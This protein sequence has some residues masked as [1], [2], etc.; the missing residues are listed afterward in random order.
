M[1]PG[2]KKQRLG[3]WDACPD[4]S[5]AAFELRAATTT[6]KLE[7]CVGE[8]GW[9]EV[10][11]FYTRLNRLQKTF[12]ASSPWYKPIIVT[13]EGANEGGRSFVEGLVDMYPQ[14]SVRMACTPPASLSAVQ[15]MFNQLGG[16][17]ARAFNVVSNY[18]VVQECKDAC[19]AEHQPLVFIIANFLS[20]AISCSQEEVSRDELWVWPPGLLKPRLQLILVQDAASSG[21]LAEVSAASKLEVEQ[22]ILRVSGLSKEEMLDMAKGGIDKAFFPSTE[23]LQSVLGAD[24]LRCLVNVARKEGLLGDSAGDKKWQLGRRGKHVSW[25]FQLATLNRSSGAPPSLRNLGIHS[26]TETGFIFFGLGSAG[27]ATGEAGEEVVASMVLLLGSYPFQQQWRGEG[28]VRQMRWGS[29]PPPV[30]LACAMQRCQELAQHAFEPGHPPEVKERMALQD[31]E[32]VLGVRSVDTPGGPSAAYIFIPFRMEVLMGHPPA[33]GGTRRCEWKRLPGSASSSRLWV[34]PRAVLPFSPQCLDVCWEQPRARKA[35]VVIMGAHTAGKSTVRKRLAE[36]TQ[37]ESDE[38]LGTSLRG[39]QEQQGKY[40]ATWDCTIH[41]A[42]VARD[43]ERRNTSRVV[44]TWHLGN[45][46]WALTRRP[47]QHGDLLQRAVDAIRQ[48]QEAGIV[49]LMLL[50]ITPETMVRRRAQF[51]TS[52]LT[53]QDEETDAKKLSRATGEKLKEILEEMSTGTFRQNGFEGL[54]SLPV[55]TLDNNQDGEAALK[56]TVDAIVD[57]ITFFL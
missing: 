4:L 19:M 22:I 57:F 45:F 2:C 26:V 43:E 44:E 25:S 37:W 35:T 7:A 36:R 38:E 47:E 17:A 15:G 23:H 53:F 55:L 50:T 9:T 52:A 1:D 29:P 12:D 51:P 10:E 24:P 31:Q 28:V 8:D 48:E 46:V 21:Q 40:P 18:M 54:K 34:G 13:V 49:L 3:P 56:D 42:E 11:G 20:S 41:Q 6:S 30:S 39:E 32:A 16:A 14:S 5:T 33:P 27:G